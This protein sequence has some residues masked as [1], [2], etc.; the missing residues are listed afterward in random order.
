MTKSIAFAADASGLGFVAPVL[1]SIVVSDSMCLRP[2]RIAGLLLLFLLPACGHAERRFESTCQIVR[3]DV[4][5]EAQDGTPLLVDL[6]LEWDPCPGDQFQVIR[7]GKE[8]AACMQRH[9]VGTLVPVLV[10]QW[11][12]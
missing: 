7:G 9:E 1:V 11:W 12:D 6:E 3:R 4:V 10:K 2:A 8:F 5:E